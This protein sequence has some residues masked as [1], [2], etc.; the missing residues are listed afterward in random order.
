E[1]SSSANITQ[2][3]NDIKTEGNN[4]KKLKLYFD[5]VIKDRVNSFK[6]VATVTVPFNGEIDKSQL[7]KGN[8]G[9]SWSFKT[10][11][12]SGTSAEQAT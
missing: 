12:L 7:A 11:N 2:T 3:N 6:N 1:A 8:I 10:I 5:T 4:L 9:I